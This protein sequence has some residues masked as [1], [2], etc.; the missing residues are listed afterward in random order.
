MSLQ[1]R[2][3]ARRREGKGIL[4]R[5][6]AVRSGPPVNEKQSAGLSRETKSEIFK[7]CINYSVLLLKG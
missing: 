6:L 7:A 2:H 4:V 1:T 5:S 3:R